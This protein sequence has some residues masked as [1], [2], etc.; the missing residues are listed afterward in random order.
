M[1]TRSA[2]ARCNKTFPKT[3]GFKG[4]YHHWDGY[5]QGVGQTLFLAY[6]GETGTED[7]DKF[8]G[9][10]E[11]LL[12]YLIDEHPAGWSTIN[13]RPE[14]SWPE[15]HKKPRKRGEEKNY[16]DPQ[17]CTCTLWPEA[18]GDRG[19]FVT[20]KNAADVGCEWVY[21]FDVPNKK[22]YV[23]SSVNEDGSKMIG[24]FGFGNP[25][26]EWKPVACVDLEGDMPDWDVVTY[27]EEVVKLFKHYKETYSPNFGEVPDYIAH[28]PKG[29]TFYLSGCHKPGDKCE[30]DEYSSSS[31]ERQKPNRCDHIFTLP[32]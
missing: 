14:C 17:V 25:D 9:D 12:K 3:L 19:W 28:C 24:M 8:K 22:M 26:A 21:A 1:S 13:A 10:L 18:Y 2:I 4:V 6:K 20:Q 27:G 11:G 15:R 29:H 5:P 30:G 7:L 32:E 31:Q 16:N 23:L